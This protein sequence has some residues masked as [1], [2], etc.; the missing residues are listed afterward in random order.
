[1]SDADFPSSLLK[2]QAVGVGE[3]ALESKQSFVPPSTEIRL[4]GTILLLERSSSFGLG[5]RAIQRVFIKCKD[6]NASID[7][8]RSATLLTYLIDLIG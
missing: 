3:R 7:F 1:M 5:A 2:P 8:T 6:E 4:A